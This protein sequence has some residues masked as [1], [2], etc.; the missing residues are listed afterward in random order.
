MVTSVTE[1][2]ID[3][4]EQMVKQT[5]S[6]FLTSVTNLALT[7][8]SKCMVKQIPLYFN[9]HRDYHVMKESINTKYFIIPKHMTNELFSI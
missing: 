9:V 1:F 4:C 3:L 7:S 5:P 6:Y 8:I 2:V